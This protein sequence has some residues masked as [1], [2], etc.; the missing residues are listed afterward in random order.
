MDVYI[1]LRFSKGSKLVCS[2]YTYCSKCLP[3]TFFGNYLS[4]TSV[5][6]AYV[7]D[8][9]RWLCLNFQ[10]IFT[11]IAITPILFAFCLA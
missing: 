9:L 5:D 8:I 3:R 4:F 6:L 2:S 1:Y 11:V 7:Y 10:N